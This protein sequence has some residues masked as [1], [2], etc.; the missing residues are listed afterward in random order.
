[1]YSRNDEII[2][3]LSRLAN[4]HSITP[5]ARNKI[6]DVTQHVRQLELEEADGRL[7]RKNHETLWLDTGY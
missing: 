6:R 1:V 4:D 3:Q 7:S 2:K 5:Q